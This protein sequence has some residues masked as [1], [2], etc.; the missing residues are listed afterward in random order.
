MIY[1]YP[2]GISSPLGHLDFFFYETTSLS[3]FFS[4]IIQESLIRLRFVEQEST[5]IILG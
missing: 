5:C 1:S 3:F 4:D 2:G